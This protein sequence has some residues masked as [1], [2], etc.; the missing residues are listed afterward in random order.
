MVIVV[1]AL[2]VFGCSSAG[3][4][5]GTTTTSGVGGGG[6]LT[7]EPCSVSAPTEC[8]DPAPRYADVAPVLEAKCVTC[9]S[10][11]AGGP[12]PLTDYPHVADWQSEVRSE[13]LDC[14]MPP[15]DAGASI[16]DDE[17]TLILTWL[18]CGAPE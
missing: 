9:H 16:T 10:G 12:W 7:P 18:R 13:L 8:P 17:R 15:A 6:G 2:V 1:D 14:S 4:T 3:G 11:A 5:S